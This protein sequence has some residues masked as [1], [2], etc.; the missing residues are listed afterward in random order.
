MTD[1][2]GFWRIDA[3][4]PETLQCAPNFVHCPSGTLARDGN[5]GPLEGWTWFDS[6]MAAAAYYELPIEAADAALAEHGM[7]RDG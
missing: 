5:R 7:T 2:S 3:Q 4:D 6:A 1:T